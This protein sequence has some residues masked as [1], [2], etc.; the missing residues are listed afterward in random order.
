MKD[1]R[2]KIFAIITVITL[3][4]SLFTLY[5]YSADGFKNKLSAKAAAL[6]EPETET[7]LFSQN[8][9]TR[10]PM[11]STTKIMTALVVLENSNP[12]NVI[13]IDERA[14]GIEGS[15]IYLEKEEALSVKSLLY[16]LLLQSANDAA[17][18]LA[19]NISGEIE[20]FSVLMNE[21][22]QALGLED[23][24][25]TNPHGLDSEN[26]YT[27]AHDLA[28]IA[29]HALKNPFFREITATKKAVIESSHKK[30][31]LVNHN[32]MLSLYDGCIGVKTGY[33]KKSGR[34]LVSAAEK[35]GL[36]LIAVTIN[37]PEDWIDH[38]NL[39]DY[40]FARFH[41]ITLIGKDGL[42]KTIPVIDGKKQYLTVKNKDEINMIFDGEIPN[43]ITEIRLKQF[44]VAPISAGDVVGSVIFKSDDKEIAE[45]DII[46][47][48]T[49]EKTKKSKL[50][51]F[52]K[53][54]D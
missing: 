11:A 34:S 48:E 13:E 32:K 8:E 28:I 21:K 18:A 37:A 41:K 45:V 6:Y 4:F 19:Y 10:L 7:F 44:A 3:I 20:A 36:T 26:H 35:N 30:R 49:I 12:E 14:I 25:F 43:I 16:A 17:A 5:V 33:T 42:T 51:S 47:T 22:A 27:T 23:T 15:S 31:L 54:E 40:G 39:L 53:T 46:A 9:K 50:F 38:K 1:N 2:H 29:A 52:N 24:N